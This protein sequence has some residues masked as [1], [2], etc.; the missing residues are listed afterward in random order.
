MLGNQKYFE[1]TTQHNYLHLI[2]LLYGTKEKYNVFKKIK[3][4]KKL[5]LKTG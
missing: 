5:R 2:L 1:Y 3:A 4:H